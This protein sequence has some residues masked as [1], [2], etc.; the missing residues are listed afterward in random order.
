MRDELERVKAER[1]V[2]QMRLEVIE[3]VT[4]LPSPFAG[5]APLPA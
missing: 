1:D 2:L 3:A 5:S 4:A